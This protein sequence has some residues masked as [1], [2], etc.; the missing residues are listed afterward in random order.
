[1]GPRVNSHQTHTG[2]TVPGRHSRPVYI[3]SVNSASLC[4]H[5]VRLTVTFSSRLLSHVPGALTS[6]PRGLCADFTALRT[7]MLIPRPPARA[8]RRCRPRCCLCG[9]LPAALLSET[10][11][12]LWRSQWPTSCASVRLAIFTGSPEFCIKV[13]GQLRGDCP[14]S[15]EIQEPGGGGA[16]ATKPTD[17]G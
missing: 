9:S 2:D 16:T 15:Q 7:A 17:S 13:T 14:C 8:L 11:V 10:P 1:M 3:L 6:A 12:R 4:Y 5:Q